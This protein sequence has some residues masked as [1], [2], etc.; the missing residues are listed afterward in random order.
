MEQILRYTCGGCGKTWLSNDEKYTN[1]QMDG[2]EC[3][4]CE[5]Q[6]ISA[7]IVKE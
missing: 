5:S 7:V 6:D 2:Y 4:K 3:P 1:D